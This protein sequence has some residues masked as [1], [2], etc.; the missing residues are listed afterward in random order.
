[1]RHSLWLALACTSGLLSGCESMNP[2]E[3]RSAD[4]YQVGYQAGRDGQPRAHIE[5]LSASCI[6]ANVIPDREGYFAGRERGLREYCTAEHGFYLGRNG[7]GYRAVCPP[8]SAHEF[9]LA[10]DDGHRV[11]EAKQRIHHLEN[12]RH[13]LEERLAQ[14][15]SDQDKKQVRDELEELDRRLHFS[16]DTLQFIDHQSRHGW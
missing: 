1:M 15:H 2:Q 8:E 4:W 13:E 7:S 12:K 16:R 5:D 11:Y 9:E 6:K 14:T 3:C 10:Y